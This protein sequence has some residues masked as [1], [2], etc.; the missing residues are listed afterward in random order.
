MKFF[1]LAEPEGRSSWVGIGKETEEGRGQ[2]G[3]VG[4][5]VLFTLLCVFLSPPDVT[6]KGRDT[7]EV[8][9]DPDDGTEAADFGREEEA[10]HLPSVQKIVHR[11]GSEPTRAR[12]K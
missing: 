3:G 4:W 6:A 1:K 10:S 11:S 12:A 5:Q 8:E 7:E 2:R 9:V